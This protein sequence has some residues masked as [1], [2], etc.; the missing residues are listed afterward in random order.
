MLLFKL[1]KIKYL[2]VVGLLA[3]N[4]FGSLSHAK[5]ADACVEALRRDPADVTDRPESLRAHLSHSSIWKI[6]ERLLERDPVSWKKILLERYGKYL[7][8][9]VHDP[10]QYGRLQ[11][12]INK[13]VKG[14]AS[15]LGEL[16]IAEKYLSDPNVRFV[17]WVREGTSKTPDFIVHYV[18]GGGKLVEVKTR[19][20]DELPS[21]GYLL[22]RM[23][24][25]DEQIGVYK[26]AAPA[27]QFMRAEVEFVFYAS[28]STGWDVLLFQELA[29]KAIAHL[30]DRENLTRVTLNLNNRPIYRAI[31]VLSELES[32]GV[33]HHGVWIRKLSRHAKRL[34]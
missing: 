32:V 9:Y 7:P 28:H 16:Q 12:R 25:A 14:K 24:E 15:E 33:E 29:E 13:A 30:T 31:R 3:L 6:R 17:E 23:R 4:P 22:S 27:T 11:S 26:I 18:D 21:S 8:R 5:V 10:V 20:K 19:C 1:N 2:V 34:R